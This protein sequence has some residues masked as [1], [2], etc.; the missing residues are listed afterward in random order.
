LWGFAQL[1]WNATVDAW[2]TYEAALRFGSYGA[3]AVVAAQALRRRAVL[4]VFLEGI[5]WFG[6]AVSVVSVLAYFTSPSKVLWLFPSPYPDV[7]GPFLSRNNFAQFLELAMPAALWLATKRDRRV[8]L[9]T[10]ATMLAAG[11]A[12]A[13]RAGAILLA[14][15]TVVVFALAGSTGRRRLATFLSAATLLVAIAGAG[16]LAD[17]FRDPDPLRYRLEMFQSS[18]HMIAARP[19]QGYGLGTYAV[20]YP[21]FAEFD[22]GAVVEHAHNDWLEWTSEGGLPFGALWTVLA[23]ALCRPAICSI[24]GLGVVALFLH[25]LV[26]YPFARHGVAAWAF[27]LAGALGRVREE[28]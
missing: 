15:E 26:D 27:I 6:T 5:A 18:W 10:G 17:R 12:S 1:A 20:V 2:A 28:T 3:T 16:T 24:W 11:V 22:S 9:L 8:H 13:S 19:W 23:L 14:A 7:W 21:E 25:A 4:E